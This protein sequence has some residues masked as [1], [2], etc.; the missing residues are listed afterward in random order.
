MNEKPNKGK[1]IYKT[2]GVE[3]N[4]RLECDGRVKVDCPLSKISNVKPKAKTY[5]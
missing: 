5:C 4:Q 3:C 1:C 2:L